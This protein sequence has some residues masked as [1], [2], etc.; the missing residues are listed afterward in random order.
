MIAQLE[1]AKTPPIFD[2]IAVENHPIRTARP[3]ACHAAYQ[4][5]F[6]VM[7]QRFGNMSKYQLGKLLGIEEQGNF[8]Q[9][10]NGRMRPS[11]LVLA[12]AFQLIFMSDAGI[13]IHRASKIEWGDPV[14]I[15]WRNGGKSYPSSVSGRWE[16]IPTP[17]NP[18]EPP[19]ANHAAKPTRPTTTHFKRRPNIPQGAN[20]GS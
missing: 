8:R 14:T 10:F 6:T 1:C 19:G 11:S 17:E 15:V 13:E 5:I 16:Q 20:N 9:Y 4:H 7:M 2:A 18:T 3:Y 12:R